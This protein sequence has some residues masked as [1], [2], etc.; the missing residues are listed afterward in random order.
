[1]MALK[2]TRSWGWIYPFYGSLSINE[3]GSYSFIRVNSWMVIILVALRSARKLSLNSR[4][5]D[6][7]RGSLKEEKRNHLTAQI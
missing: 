2:F 3:W 1:M 7:D 6:A 4:T 5:A